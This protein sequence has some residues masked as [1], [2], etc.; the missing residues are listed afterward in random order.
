MDNEISCENICPVIKEIGR[1][2]WF[3]TRGSVVRIHSPRSNLIILVLVFGLGTLLTV[4]AAAGGY[5]A[6]IG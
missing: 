4:I 5:R 2:V 6:F 1:V 3:G